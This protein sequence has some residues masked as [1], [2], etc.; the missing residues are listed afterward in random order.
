MRHVAFV[1]VGA[2]QGGRSDRLTAETAG[3]LDELDV[4]RWVWNNAS[5]GKGQE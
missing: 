3:Y 2:E 1:T 5:M 4:C